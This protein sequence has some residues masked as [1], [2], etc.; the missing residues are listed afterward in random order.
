MYHSGTAL[1]DPARIFETIHLSS[2]MRVAD[3]GCG[4]TGHFVFPM[5]PIIGEKGMVYAID[6]MKDVLENIRSRARAEGRNN[7]QTIWSDLEVFGATPIPEQSLDAGFFI[8]VV[9]LLKKR[10]EALREA[11]RL[12]RDDGYLIVVDWQKRVG[13]LGPMDSQMVNQEE[14]VQLAA[15]EKLGLVTRGPAGDYHFCLI[16]KK[17]KKV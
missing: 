10:P 13:P 11:A 2:G 9:F 14:L 8:N 12:I 1:I 17:E 3:F 5:A 7:I 16:F 15:K 6:I 4:R